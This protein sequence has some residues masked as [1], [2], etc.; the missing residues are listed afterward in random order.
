MT[1]LYKLKYDEVKL[2][3]LGH[4]HVGNIFVVEA[5]GEEG[6]MCLLGGYENTLLSYRAH[7]FRAVLQCNQLPS[8]DVIMFGEWMWLESCDSWTCVNRSCDLWD[9]SW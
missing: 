9:V 1:K 2:E 5:E 6:E 4:V 3:P 8:I 7:L